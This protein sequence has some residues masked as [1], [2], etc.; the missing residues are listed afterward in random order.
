M[1]TFMWLFSTFVVHAC[2]YTGLEMKYQRHALLGTDRDSLY[3]YRLSWGLDA[4]SRTINTKKDA[5]EGFDSTN[6]V[7]FGNDQTEIFYKIQNDTLLIYSNKLFRYPSNF[8]FHVALE[9]LEHDDFP[10]YEEAYRQGQLEKMTFDEDTV[11][12][13]LSCT[14]VRT[15][16]QYSSKFK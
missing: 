6:D 9:H 11:M 15:E 10:K 14:P 5:C 8:R 1:K 7:C 3:C 12:D 2:G 13:Y 16:S 4:E